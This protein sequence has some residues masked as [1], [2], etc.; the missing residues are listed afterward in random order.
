[1]Q[2]NV[3]PSNRAKI[4]RNVM[5]AET[6]NASKNLNSDLGPLMPFENEVE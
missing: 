5:T 4:A 1:M 2:S 6:M 3:R